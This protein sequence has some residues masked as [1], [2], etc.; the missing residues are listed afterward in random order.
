MCKLDSWHCPLLADKSGDSSQA[1]HMNIVPDTKI[2]EANAP[3]F[4]HRGGLSHDKACASNCARAEVHEMPIGC[5]TVFA[6]ILAHGGNHDSIAEG[7]RTDGEGGKE[8]EHP[9]CTV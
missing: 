4:M 9:F 1:R 6:G 3:M 7:H 5:V 8:H 2:L